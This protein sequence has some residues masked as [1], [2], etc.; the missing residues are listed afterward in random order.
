MKIFYPLLFLAAAPIAAYA[1]PTIGPASSMLPG[2]NSVIHFGPLVDFH[3][4]GTPNV[5]WDHS[6]FVATSSENA[7]YVAPT[8]GAPAG[9]TVTEYSGGDFR[10][11]YKATA[12][13]MEMIG[14]QSA[15][16]QVDFSCPNGMAVIPYPLSYGTQTTDAFNCA[17]IISGFP[18]TRNGET[19]FNGTGWG[20]LILPYGIVD[21]VLMV[22]MQQTMVDNV[23]GQQFNYAAQMQIFMKPG[24]RQPVFGI[25]TAGYV[26][27]E[28]TTYTRMLDQVALGMDEAMS[29]AIGIDIMPNPATDRIEVVYSATGAGMSF[30]VFDSMGRIVLSSS[31]T[32]S[33]VGALREVIDVSTLASGTYN[34]RLTDRNGAS[35]VK[36]FVVN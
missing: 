9:T 10:T 7:E 23:A 6:A 18:M 20:T 3:A 33:A 36:R 21:N 34:L 15:S 22:D 4:T 31:N 30:D 24:V 29:N 11:H 28:Q 17:G 32:A 12:A 16:Q 27:L 19:T 5:T 13:A 14:V 8:A 1:Q 26:G 35:G 25:Y 2:D